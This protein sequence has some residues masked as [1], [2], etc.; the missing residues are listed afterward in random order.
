MPSACPFCFVSSCQFLISCKLSLPPFER[1]GWVLGVKV[2]AFAHHALVFY[3][4]RPLV[5]FPMK[6][7]LAAVY[8]AKENERKNLTA[9]SSQT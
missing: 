1:T 6:F 2:A 7:L 9:H 8:N 5:L 3:G 4:L